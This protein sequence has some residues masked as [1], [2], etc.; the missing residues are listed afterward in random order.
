MK[1]IGIIPA[2]YASTRFPGKPLVDIGGKSMIQRVYDQA[3]LATTLTDV[4]VA[5]DDDRIESHVQSFGGRVVRTRDDHPSGTDRVAEVAALF[6]DA[7]AIINIQGDEPFIDPGLIDALAGLLRRPE[8]DIVTLARQ[9][10]QTDDLFNPNHVKVVLDDNQRALYFSRSAIP[11]VRGVDPTL[12]VTRAAYYQHIGL[13][14]YKQEVLQAIVDLSQGQLEMVESLE[15]LRWLAAGYTIRVGITEAD[16]LG[17]DTPADLNAALA[18][19][20]RN[21]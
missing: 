21:S 15:Q 17:I 5:T 6:K 2:R 10:K 13:Y 18:W 19:L 9:I 8:T 12:W 20:S 16:S 1:T 7:T 14:G 3:C 11:Y 4:I